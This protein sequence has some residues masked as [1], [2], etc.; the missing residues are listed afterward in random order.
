LTNMGSGQVR[1]AKEA[2]A[3][4]QPVPGQADMVFIADGRVF[5]KETGNMIAGSSYDV[6]TGQMMT[7]TGVKMT[8]EA[9][10]KMG[11]IEGK[12]EWVY[13]PQSGQVYNKDT[14]LIIPNWMFDAVSG[15]LMNMLSGAK[16]EPATGR[17]FD[18]AT[19][20]WIDKKAAA[21]A[22]TLPDL[23]GMSG[24]GYDNAGIVYDKGSGQQQADMQYD[25]ATGQLT[26][27]GQILTLVNGEWTPM[28]E[29]AAPAAPAVP[30]APAAPAG[31]TPLPN[32]HG[33]PGYGYDN[34]GQV[35]GPDGA[36]SG[37][38]YN[39][40]SDQIYDPNDGAVRDPATGEWA[41]APVAAP[42]AAMPAQAG[43]QEDLYEAYGQFYLQ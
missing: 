5:N 21:Q 9:M 26:Y 6:A 16:E 33:L 15:Q 36:L 19:G 38:M 13:D 41:A 40:Q 1:L 12:D 34:S 31:T 24:F 10:K 23:P 8:P 43:G 18:P 32:V 20:Q 35:L 11:T 17:I 7:L 25:A 28:A 39:A 37:F 42:A 4:A 22:A 27:Q 14:A 30:A 3:A 29:A 2:L